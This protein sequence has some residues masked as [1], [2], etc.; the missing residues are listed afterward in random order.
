MLA[1]FLLGY[2]FLC[3]LG[4]IFS[5]ELALFDIFL[6]SLV[7]FSV[8]YFIL[9]KKKIFVG[10]LLS[11]FVFGSIGGIYLYRTE[12]LSL[13]FEPIENF[14]KTCY[15]SVSV[16]DYYIGIEFQRI[17]ILILGVFIYKVLKVVYLHDK[18]RWI[19]PIIG[20]LIFL[21]ALFL[22][23]LNTSFDQWVF[24]IFTMVSIIYYFESYYVYLKEYTLS[25][26]KVSFYILGFLIGGFI[27]F[28]AVTLNRIFPDPFKERIK[29]ISARGTA[30]IDVLS[31]YYDYDTLEKVLQSS[32]EYKVA[33]EFNHQGIELFKV[34]TDKLKYYKNQSFDVYNQGAWVSSKHNMLEEVDRFVQPVF[35]GQEFQENENYLSEAFY[36]DEVEIIARNIY[37]DSIITAPFTIDLRTASEYIKFIP[38]EDEMVKTNEM[39]ERG[40]VYRF[41]AFIPKY[42]TKIYK[43]FLEMA[44]IQKESVRELDLTTYLQLPSDYD[45]VI[46]LAKEIT[47]GLNSPYDKAEAIETYLHDNYVYNEQP[48]F[49]N[50]GD[51]IY[52]FL[53]DKKEGFC[54]QFATSMSLMLRAVDVP[55]RFVV[56]YV[57][58][59]VIEEDEIPSE[60]LYTEDRIRDPYFHIYDSNAHAWVEVY[61]ENVG[62]VQYEPTPGQSRVQF[63]DPKEDEE[64][65]FIESNEIIVET[66]MLKDQLVYIIIGIISILI[67]S[68]L[69]LL[70]LRI[71]KHKKDDKKRCLKDYR[72][73]LM[74]LKASGVE[75]DPWETLR[76]YTARVKQKKLKTDK[77][78]M[79]FV[80]VY[81]DVFYNDGIPSLKD[82]ESIETYIKNVK[83]NL[84]RYV[85]SG[86]Y[87]QLHMLEWIIFLK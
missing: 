7:C 83:N 11:I 12:Q 84:K 82:I 32:N 71:K 38:Y 2:G 64:K 61:S 56:G 29:A 53:F 85:R 65:D 15:Y 4:A 28:S 63:T 46:Q 39:F 27:L 33:S 81:E 43:E 75:K 9:E 78:F 18:V 87:L 47:V 17:L 70:N 72:I 25:K 30:D 26:R 49:E 52:E 23:L 5:Y 77:E 36:M 24:I 19:S 3:I 35:L 40:F 50:T 59:T 60:F 80:D 66:Q 41:S 1:V 6:I 14:F 31:E 68:L 45:E 8:F 42:D 67:I 51:M 58:E 37:A 55:S 86:R 22:N 69:L 10:V 48:G 16:V 34:K 13:V 62:W 44:M 73:L 74:Y 21:V 54:Q 57:I 20:Y 76:E 79:N